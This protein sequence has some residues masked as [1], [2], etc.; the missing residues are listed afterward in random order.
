[1]RGSVPKTERFWDGFGR[2]F[3]LAQITIGGSETQWKTTI[4]RRCKPITVFYHLYKLFDIKKRQF[5]PI[6]GLKVVVL[7]PQMPL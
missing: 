3:R 4:S 6:D 5:M 2:L 7:A 1:M